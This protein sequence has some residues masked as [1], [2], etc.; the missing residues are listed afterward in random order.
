MKLGTRQ[1]RIRVMK[2]QP[3]GPSIEHDVFHV[4]DEVIPNRKVN[5]TAL[6]T[7]CGTIV[8]VRDDGRLLIVN[9]HGTHHIVSMLE[10]VPKPRRGGNHDPN[11]GRVTRTASV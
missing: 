2:S 4:G 9:T 3:V 8:Q 11:A 6:L 10:V 7:Y 1:K 5:R